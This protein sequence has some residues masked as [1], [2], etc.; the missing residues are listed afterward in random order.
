MAEPLEFWTYVVTNF[1]MFGFGLLLTGLSYFAYRSDKTRLALRNA[2]IGFGLLTVG[3]L[4]AP[5]YQIGYKTQYQLDGRELLAVQSVEGLFLAAGL[6]ML[7]YSIYRY[8]NGRQYHH[9]EAF[10][11]VEE[12]EDH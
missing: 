1:M 3:G 10:E 2:T 4:I 7:F 12:V 9:V 5:L 8:S 6:G 11:T